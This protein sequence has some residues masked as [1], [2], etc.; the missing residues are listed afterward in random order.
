[1]LHGL[2][3]TAVIDTFDTRLYSALATT[4]LLE[5]FQTTVLAAGCR[6]AKGLTS[7]QLFSLPCDSLYLTARQRRLTNISRN[8]MSR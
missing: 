4:T 8:E 7:K 2:N 6:A 3:T 1:M 5:G